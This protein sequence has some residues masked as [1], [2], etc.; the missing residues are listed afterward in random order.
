MIA[1]IKESYT[2]VWRRN[3]AGV[4]AKTLA[5]TVVTLYWVASPVIF[6]GM[7]TALLIKRAIAH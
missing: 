2:N 3:D 7:F 4:V 6:A 1:K 5:T